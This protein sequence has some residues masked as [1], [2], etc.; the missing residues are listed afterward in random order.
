MVNRGEQL[1]ALWEERKAHKEE[2]AKHVWKIMNQA[3]LICILFWEKPLQTG[4]HKPILNRFCD[5]FTEVT[6]SSY[7]TNKP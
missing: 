1:V 6:L 7:Q 5:G 2:A 4:D 3:W